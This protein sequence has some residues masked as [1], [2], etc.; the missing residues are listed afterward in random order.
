MGD[1]GSALKDDAMKG[2]SGGIRGFGEE[3]EGGRPHAS[4]ATTKAMVET[5]F[6]TPLRRVWLS[7]THFTTFFRFQFSV[8]VPHS[9][10]STTNC[11]SIIRSELLWN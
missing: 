6:A 10:E 2:M 8:S 9:A 11:Q 5:F 7:L 3:R 1:R 4:D